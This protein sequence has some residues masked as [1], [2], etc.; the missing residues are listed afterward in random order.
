MMM[1]GIKAAAQAAGHRAVVFIQG[2]QAERR[3]RE[4]AWR[5]AELKWQ[6]A[7]SKDLDAAIGK[8]TYNDAFTKY[9]P[10]QVTISRPSEVIAIYQNG[11]VT[12]RWFPISNQ[13]VLSCFPHGS[14]LELNFSA[15]TSLV[16]W[17]YT[18]W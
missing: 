3:Q 2:V 10:P 1:R 6:Q 5:Q 17:K 14:R 12:F 11:R 4:K 13:A 18:E 16:S 7:L 8:L 9:G 15:T